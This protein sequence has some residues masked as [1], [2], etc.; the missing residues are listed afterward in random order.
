M[1]PSTSARQTALP[2]E[3]CTAVADIA[4]H[5][6]SNLPFADAVSSP[7]QFPADDDDSGIDDGT[8]AG[9]ECVIESVFEALDGDA[10]AADEAE[11]VAYADAVAHVGSG[12]WADATLGAAISRVAV[13][14]TRLQSLLFVIVGAANAVTASAPHSQ[15]ALSD[16][17]HRTVAD[18]LFAEP[19]AFFGSLIH[20]WIGR[21]LALFE[22]A[23]SVA[24]RL[25][26]A[27]ARAG[28]DRGDAVFARLAQT[29]WWTNRARA[30]RSFFD[31]MSQFQVPHFGWLLGCRTDQCLCFFALACTHSRN[32]SRVLIPRIA[33][34]WRLAAHSRAAVGRTSRAHRPLARAV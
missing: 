13:C 6:H 23:Q 11:E 32:I 24:A 1:N 28:S 14:S 26:A 29:R 18:A 12:V 31:A 21:H 27:A 8:A 34:L 7:L 22:C 15:R 20:L 19:P 4:R 33:A 30:L 10:S 17:F 16:R 5:I 2:S 25:G 3:G 9:A